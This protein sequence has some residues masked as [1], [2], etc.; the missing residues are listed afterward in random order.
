MVYCRYLIAMALVVMPTAAAQ[1]R[2]T[3]VGDPT[4]ARPRPPLER[5]MAKLP[6]PIVWDTPS[7]DAR[8][9][10]PLGNGDIALNAW[11]DPQGD[12][13]FYIAKSDAWEDHGRL[14]KV[15]RMR[16]RCTPGLLTLG[17]QFRQ[18]LDLLRGQ[19][20]V[21]VARPGE[22]PAAT[23]RLWVD[24]NHPVIHIATQSSQPMGVEASTEIWRNQPEALSS[25]EV[26]DVLL[27]RS[28]PAGQVAPTIVEPDT[29]L[30]ADDIPDGVGWYH[31]NVKSVGPNETMAF[32]DLAGAPWKE[33]LL[34]RTFGAWIRC[35]G[36]QRM[37]DTR[38]A[39]PASTTNCFDIYVLTQHPA[40]PQ[41]W[42]ASVRALA[43]SVESIAP[44]ARADAH[45]Q[46]WSEFWDR[47]HIA[48]S[49]RTG[50]ADAAA[51]SQ[52]YTLQRFMTACAGRG[53]Y[54]IKFNGSLFNTPW[55]GKP[56][57]G[58]YRRWGPGYWWQ[59]TRLMYE[60]LSTSGDF[61]LQLPLFRMYGQDILAVSKYRTKRYFG[62]DDAAYFPEVMYFWGAVFPDTYGLKTPAAERTDKLQSSPWH[63]YEWVGGLELVCLMHDYYLHTDDDRFLQETLLPTAL[64]ILRFFDCYY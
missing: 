12:L 59:N 46:W 50:N 31:H 64:P 29:T 51:V 21:T 37:S 13:L 38:L 35:T 19:V 39:A 42:I 36:G 10:M 63:K 16:L 5:T 61:D 11:V 7:T 24:A 8:G 2:T 4:T 25:I 55:P 52:G 49:S 45:L 47:S 56:G 1:H 27:D 48:I 34:H 54:P 41:V 44:D 18:E 6:P 28:V 15:G 17:S 26:S 32:Q 3:P 58:D 33:P 14:A 9:S 53:A 43:A 57:D 30:K 40:T 62:F 23:I 20:I 60:S 22:A